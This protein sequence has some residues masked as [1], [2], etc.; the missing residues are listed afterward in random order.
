MERI[1]SLQVLD[2]LELKSEL[3]QPLSVTIEIFL[4]PKLVSSCRQCHEAQV[5]T[6]TF[7]QQL[8]GA[9]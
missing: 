5:T 6:R 3:E 1:V 2:M 9:V 7:A 4:E 8:A